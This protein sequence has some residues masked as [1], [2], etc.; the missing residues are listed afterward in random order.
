MKTISRLVQDESGTTAME[1]GLIAGLLSL[2]VITGATAT[3]TAVNG[4]FTTI[5]TGLAAAAVVIAG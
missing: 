1:Y 2:A 5:G 4:M 3:G